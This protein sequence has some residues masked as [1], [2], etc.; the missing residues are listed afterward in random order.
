MSNAQHR[1][2]RRGL[3]AALVTVGLAAA[4]GAGPASGQAEAPP[5]IVM[6][7]DRIGLRF[8]GP[9]QVEEGQTLRIRNAT[10]PDQIGPH[11]FSIVTPRA[12][13]TTLRARKRCFTAGHI[14]RTVAVNGHKFN[15]KTGMAGRNVAKAGL[16]GWD[17]AF[18]R[19]P[20]SIG[21]SWFTEA[22][23]ATFS[24]VVSAKAGTTLTYL[25]AIHPEMK[26]KIDVVPG[27]TPPTP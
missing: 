10:S 8:T 3:P 26:G 12:L 6:K 24:Q 23:G 22:K 27:A 2:L 9:K 19:N 11:T 17:K 4:L 20:E 15:P 5:T 7:L 14:C 16:A 13:P 1:A 21:D 18:S 25:C